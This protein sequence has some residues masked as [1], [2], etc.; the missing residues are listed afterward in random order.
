[1]VC[2]DD[3]GCHVGIIFRFLWRILGVLPD[4]ILVFGVDLRQTHGM[5]SS[6]M[7]MHFFDQPDSACACALL[8]TQCTQIIVDDPIGLQLKPQKLDQLSL[9]YIIQ[10][11]TEY[12]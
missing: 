5:E 4:G 12:M 8:V 6:S 2:V 3:L 10:Y 1:M 9:F 7:P 11:D